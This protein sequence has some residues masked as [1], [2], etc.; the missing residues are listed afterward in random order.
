MKIDRI[1]GILMTLI[2][3]KR[4]TSEYLSKKYE[5]STRTI[6]RDIEYLDTLG[7][8]VYSSRGINGGFF[9]PSDYKFKYNYFNKSDIQHILMGLELLSYISYSNETNLVINKML[10]IVPDFIDENES[11]DDYI[12]FDIKEKSPEKTSETIGILRKSLDDNITVILH[13]NNNI[14]EFEPLSIVIKDFNVCV[15]GYISI[16]NEFENTYV[17]IDVNNIDNI[18]ITNN[19]YIRKPISYKSNEL[20]TKI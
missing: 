8:P 19:E 20:I 10:N 14:H 1:L 4:V 13:I 12:V 5:V 17:L 9:I 6:L 7:V 15:Y 18:S 16:S 3:E 2:K 11:I